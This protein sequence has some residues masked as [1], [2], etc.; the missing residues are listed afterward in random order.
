MPYEEGVERM[1]WCS[2]QRNLPPDNGRAQGRS[3]GPSLRWGYN[4]HLYREGRERATLA[5]TARQ[6]ALTVPLLLL[7]Q[8]PVRVSCRGRGGIT[9]NR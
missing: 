8:V 3:D 2:I 7:C 4:T 6:K 5:T 1:G 9:V